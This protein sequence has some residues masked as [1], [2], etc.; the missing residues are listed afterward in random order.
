MEIGLG[1]G[2]DG[3][4]ASVVGWGGGGAEDLEE[5]EGARRVEDLGRGM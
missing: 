1:L 2:V 5:G 4:W 3:V